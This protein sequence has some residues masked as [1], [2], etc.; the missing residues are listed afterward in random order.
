M[1]G[2]KSHVSRQKNAGAAPIV[3]NGVEGNHVAVEYALVGVYAASICPGRVLV[4]LISLD[5]ALDGVH[6]S[7]FGTRRIVFEDISNQGGLEA[8]YTATVRGNIPL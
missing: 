3:G 6:A 7:A 1:I 8:I 2:G 4:Y 5:S